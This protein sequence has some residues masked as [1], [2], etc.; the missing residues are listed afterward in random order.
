MLLVPHFYT[1][2]QDLNCLQL[3]IKEA[4]DTSYFNLIVTIGLTGEQEEIA[5]LRHV[6]VNFVRNVN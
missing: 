3:N 5:T 2:L 1:T 6:N 4:M